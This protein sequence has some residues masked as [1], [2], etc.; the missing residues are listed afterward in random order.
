MEGGHIQ[1]CEEVATSWENWCGETPWSKSLRKFGELGG[2][3][4]WWCGVPR[5]A[6]AIPL[7]FVLVM[8]D[9]FHYQGHSRLRDIKDAIAAIS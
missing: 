5:S 6:S 2:K 8:P 9:G 4:I 1:T 7:C 3:V